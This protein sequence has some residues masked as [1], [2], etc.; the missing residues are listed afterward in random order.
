MGARFI[1]FPGKENFVAIQ[2]G[3]MILARSTLLDKKNIHDPL[4]FQVLKDGF[5]NLIPSIPMEGIWMS[6]EMETQ[7]GNRIKLCDYAS[8]GKDYKKPEDPAAVEEMLNN[9]TKNEL[10][11]WLPV[12]PD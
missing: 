6:F 12:I 11:V 10:R 7:P 1:P 3:P 9:R 4:K 2:R 8:T 5:F